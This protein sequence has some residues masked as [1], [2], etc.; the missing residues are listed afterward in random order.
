M[1][2]DYKQRAETLA[3]SLLND[4][5]TYISLSNKSFLSIQKDGQLTDSDITAI[6]HVDTSIS[7]EKWLTFVATCNPDAATEYSRNVFQNFPDH[8]VAPGGISNKQ[9]K[10]WLSA[11]AT[12]INKSLS[13]LP[14]ENH[15]NVDFSSLLS[16]GAD[17]SFFEWAKAATI[18]GADAGLDSGALHIVPSAHK[19]A[20][21]DIFNSAKY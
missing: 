9:V 17:A 7:I 10:F 16:K 19:D 3:F 14:D 13:R 4:V 8:T 18:T 15:K 6:R 11:I 20:I 21:A 2:T 12:D 5:Q 1:C